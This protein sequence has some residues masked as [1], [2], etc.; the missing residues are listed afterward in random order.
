M[1]N[2][3]VLSTWEE[4]RM[5]IKAVDAT[6]Q[7][8]TLST[9]RNPYGAEKNARYWV[10]YALT[11]WT[12]RASGIWIEPMESSCTFPCPAKTSNTAQ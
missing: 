1:S 2:F 10:E 9:K 7:V 12:R 6:T 11:P 3:V 5:F 4:Y 8:A